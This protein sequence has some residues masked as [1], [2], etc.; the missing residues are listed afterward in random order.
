MDAS[1]LKCLA[2]KSPSSR[3][4]KCRVVCSSEEVGTQAQVWV[5]RRV[6]CDEEKPQCRRCVS[7]GRK[8]GY[9]HPPSVVEGFGSCYNN[10]SCR[11]RLVTCDI[12]S[13]GSSSPSFG[14]HPLDK[15]TISHKHLSERTEGVPRLTGREFPLIYPLAESWNIHFIPFVI[16][17][18]RLSFQMAK[19][20][21]D[22]VPD[23]LS[24]AEEESA[25]YQACNAVACAYMA[26]ITR[27]SKATSD[28]AKTYGIALMAIRS[29]IQNPQQCKSDNTLLAIWLLGLYELLLGTRNDTEPVAT[30]GWQIHNQVLSEMIRLRGSEQF[31]T[32]NGRNLFVVIFSNVET[33][34]LISGKESKEAFAWFLQFHKYCEPS[35]YPMLRACIFS[36]HCARI[37]SRIRVLVDTGDLDEVLSNSPS[38]LQDIDDVEQATQPLSHEKAV[39]SYVVEP[40]LT[41]YARPKDPYPCYVGVH[42]LQ[43]NFRMRLSYAVLEFLGYACKAPGC[44]PQQRMIF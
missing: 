27:T 3:D 4:D 44:T 8:C 37:C 29:T 19:S 25:L 1:G 16:N 28:R 24:K 13:P 30:P 23:V 42:I 15:V 32:R 5:H 31:T 10:D 17:K 40:P 36:H 18:F 35:E 39:S 20:I 2:V 43:S 12:V 22:T 38:I 21:Y 26:N 33:K 11:Q 9:A 34:A 6:K 7:T 14:S 41:P